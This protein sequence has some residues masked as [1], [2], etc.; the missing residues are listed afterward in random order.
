MAKK[1]VGQR[2]SWF[3]KV[4][5]EELPCIHR[6]WLKGLDY[7]D[8]F[9]RHQDGHPVAKIKEFVEAVADRKRAVLTE[10]KL[11]WAAEGILWGSRGRSTSLCLKWTTF[12]TRKRMGCVS[13][14]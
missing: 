8:P 4:E 5:G 10:D 3:A 11:G 14:W 2:G 1:A 6:Y 9:V 13:G 7:H 12:P